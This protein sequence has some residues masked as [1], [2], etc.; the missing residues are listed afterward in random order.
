MRGSRISLTFINGGVQQGDRITCRGR[1]TGTTECEEGL[2]VEAEIWMEKAAPAT[3]VVVGTA[4]AVIRR[5]LMMRIRRSEPS[6]PRSLNRFDRVFWNRLWS[7]INF[8]TRDLL[9]TRERII[10]A[11]AEATA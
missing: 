6:E 4:S 3:K 11:S 8:R 5:C 7:L 9:I 10:G 2:R 1:V